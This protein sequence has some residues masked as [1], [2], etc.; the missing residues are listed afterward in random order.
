[1]QARQSEEMALAQ[2]FLN[3]LWQ[4]EHDGKRWF[5]PDISII[6]PDRIRRR[7][8][9]TTSKGLGAHTDS[10]ALERW[11]LPAYQ[12]VSPACLTATSS[13][14]IRGMRRTVPKLKSIRWITPQN[15]R[16]FAPSRAGPRS[17]ICCPVRVAS[18]RPY[19]GGDGVYSAA[20]AAG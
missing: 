7:P 2:S 9:G 6:Y 5:N 13:S 8:P 12:Q 16:Y 1:M 17:P 15:A 14:T 20:P 4:V 11:L 3:R 18:C 19:P 10:G